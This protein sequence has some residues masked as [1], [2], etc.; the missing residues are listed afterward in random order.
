MLILITDFIASQIALQLVRQGVTNEPSP[1]ASVQLVEA[2]ESKEKAIEESN[3]TVPEGQ[4]CI[5]SEKAASHEQANETPTESDSTKVG[6]QVSC[7]DD[8]P[9]DSVV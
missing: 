2:N 9:L 6:D 3:E 4:A 1:S 8:Q 7:T 5:E